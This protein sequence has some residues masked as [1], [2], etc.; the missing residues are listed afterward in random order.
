MQTT[1]TITTTTTTPFSGLFSWTT[2]ISRYQKGKTSLDLNEARC[3]GVLGC[4][5]ISWT[6]RKQC[7]LRSRQIT[8]PAPH[9]S[10]FT[11]RMLFLM[12]NQQ[13]QSTESTYLCKLGKK[14]LISV[15]PKFYAFSRRNLETFDISHAFLPLTVAKLSTLKNSP[16]FWPTLYKGYDKSPTIEMSFCYK[17]DG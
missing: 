4:S 10:T 8:T 15:T 17:T 12:P 7:A 14:Y 6:K 11:C 16:V 5:G 9:H 3:D 13:W 1:T 2:W